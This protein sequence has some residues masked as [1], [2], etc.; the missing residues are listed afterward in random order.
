ME[1][2]NR[3]IFFC[4]QIIKIVRFKFEIFFTYD[5]KN[6][7]IIMVCDAHRIYGYEKDT[8]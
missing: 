3:G 7:L 1:I 5:L 4:F 8:K 6:I 2:C